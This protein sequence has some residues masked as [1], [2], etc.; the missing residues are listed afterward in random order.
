MIKIKVG[1]DIIGYDGQTDQQLPYKSS[2]LLLLLFSHGFL[3]YQL[4]IQNL[5]DCYRFLYYLFTRPV[6]QEMNFVFLTE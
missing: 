2:S 5:Q 3:Q 1:A 4:P 6:V